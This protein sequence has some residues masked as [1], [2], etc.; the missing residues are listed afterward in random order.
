VTN[1][2]V[3]DLFWNLFAFSSVIFLLPYIVLMLAFHRLRKIDPDAKRPYKVPGNKVFIGFV[4]W[5]PVVLLVFAVF[6]F[7]IDPFEVDLSLTVPVLIGIV[8]A[9]IIEEVFVHLAPR[10]AAARAA[11]AKAADEKQIGT[12]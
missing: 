9:V 3:D 11:E 4:T 2:S 7:I 12:D 1:G 6:F 5:V 10:W 8:I